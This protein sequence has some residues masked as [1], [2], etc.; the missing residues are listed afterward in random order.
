MYFPIFDD[1]NSANP[2]PVAILTTVLH[3]ESY[4]F[5]ALLVTNACGEASTY[6]IL[7]EFVEYV[8]ISDLHDPKF[9]D[10]KVDAITIDFELLATSLE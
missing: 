10:F 3:W 6:A 9:D 1:L 8:G 7:G 2:T 5:E 4:M